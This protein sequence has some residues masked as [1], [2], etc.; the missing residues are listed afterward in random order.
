MLDITEFDE[1]D[2]AMLLATAH[3]V[4]QEW[5]NSSSDEED[6]DVE[7]DGAN[8]AVE[9]ANQGSQSMSAGVA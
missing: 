9:A 6:S 4:V 8:V 1:Y 5:P 3:Q 7:S 2:K